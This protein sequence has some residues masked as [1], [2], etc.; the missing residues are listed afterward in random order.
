[1]YFTLKILNDKLPQ[2]YQNIIKVF[3]NMI[4]GSSRAFP[5]VF[6]KKINIVTVYK[7]DTASDNSC[8]Y[9][10]IDLNSI[11]K[12]VGLEFWSLTNF[13]MGK[14][15]LFLVSDFTVQCILVSEDGYVIEGN[16][17]KM[18]FFMLMLSELWLFKVNF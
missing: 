14:L 2:L 15:I 3:V 9:L 12:N 4:S 1:M 17:Q 10:E 16:K 18:S 13:V 7:F 11:S 6:D 5:A 8:S